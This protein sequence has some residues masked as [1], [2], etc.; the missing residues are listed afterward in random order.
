MSDELTRPADPQTGQATAAPGD[1]GAGQSGMN[2]SQPT[3]QPEQ[4]PSTQA[5]A[6]EFVSAEFD[7]LPPADQERLRPHYEKIRKELQGGFTRKA[8]Q[9]AQMR[10]QYSQKVQAYDE[11]MANPVENIMKMG[12]Q[13]GLNLTQA[14]AQQVANNQQQ[15]AINPDWTPGTWEEVFAKSGEFITPKM[16]ELLKEQLNP[17]QEKIAMLEREISEVRA[18]RVKKQLDQIDPDWQMYE[19]EMRQVLEVHP[20]LAND[21]PKLYRLA[22]PEEKLLS[23]A[24]QVALKK[25]EQK[26]QAAKVESSGHTKS[27]EPAKP[28][29]TTFEEAFQNAKR[30][31]GR[32]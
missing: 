28:K 8:Q 21:I 1:A 3:T 14:Q 24:T 32:K 30:E 10:Q 17:Y 29:I 16:Q 27:S 23:K 13:Y 2:D 9:L 20:S 25:Y 22:V 7:S 15:A 4:A 6:L 5:E 18:N 11:F 26:A 31:L 12:R 19:D